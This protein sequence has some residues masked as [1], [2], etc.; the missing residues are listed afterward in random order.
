MSNAESSQSIPL[1]AWREIALR[2][3]DSPGVSVECPAC[4]ARSL[5]AAWHLVNLRALEATI[6]LKCSSCK[7]TR[8]LLLTLPPDALG[9]FPQ[10]RLAHFASVVQGEAEPVAER[11]RQHAKAMPAAAF[12]THPLW[13]EARWSATTFQWHPQSEAPPIMGLVFDNAEA[14][15]EIFREAE[16]QM[17]H[18]DR[19]EEIRVS[20]I[21]GL[22]PGQEHRPGYTVH[23]SPDPEALAAHATAED[24]VA[25]PKVV[26]FLGQ[27][28][29]HYPIPGMPP[30]LPKFKR[31]FTKHKEFLLAPVTRRPDGKLYTD[32][33]LGIIKNVIHFRY[34][35]EITT[36]DDPDGA[37]I[38]LPQLIMPPTG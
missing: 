28:N 1:P 23:I 34:L 27:W 9:F 25:D 33:M 24:F 26:L 38:V 19:F 5:S 2:A 37:A 7:V 18:T 36:P 30:L 4:H 8:N 6:D 16:R 10:E 32:P 35:S 13:A 21:E 17:N 3:I 20:I 14:G 29:R 11:I 12:T 22:V 31:E 15:K